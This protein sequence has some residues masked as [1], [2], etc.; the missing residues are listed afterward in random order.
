MKSVIKL[1]MLT[2]MLKVWW[3]D[4]GVWGSDHE[5]EGIYMNSTQFGHQLLV[6]EQN[7][8]HW[9]EIE[10]ITNQKWVEVKADK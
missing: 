1:L 5:H 7:S 3:H 2:V 6:R 8:F 4:H 9:V 10:D